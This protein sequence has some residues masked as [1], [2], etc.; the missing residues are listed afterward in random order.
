V[1]DDMSLAADVISVAA[2]TTAGGDVSVLA[3]SALGVAASGRVYS[4]SSSSLYLGVGAG[5]MTLS[6]GSQVQTGSAG[7]S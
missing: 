5:T 2:A 6:A 3:G 7:A 4:G 1:G